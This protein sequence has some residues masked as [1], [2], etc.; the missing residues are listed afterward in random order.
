M[1]AARRKKSSG[2]RSSRA[3]THAKAAKRSTTRTRTAAVAGS[4]QR[5]VIDAAVELSGALHQQSTDTATW[6]QDEVSLWRDERRETTALIQAAAAPGSK[7]PT[8]S[9]AS[10]SASISASN[11]ATA[12]V[13]AAA[14]RDSLLSAVL[15]TNSAQRL[16]GDLI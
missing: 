9:A 15:L 10:C 1:C 16:M 5:Q 6:T 11:A 8:T 7:L 12:A 2:K 4:P 14:D 13:S 3:S